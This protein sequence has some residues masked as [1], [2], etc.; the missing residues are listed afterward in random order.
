MARRVGLS[1]KIAAFVLIGAFSLLFV[2]SGSSMSESFERTFSYVLYPVLC[3]QNSFANWWHSWQDGRR[4][5]AELVRLVRALSDE[6]DNLQGHIVE[7]SSRLEYAEDTKELRAFAYRY[8]ELP[9]YGILAQVLVRNLSEQEQFFLVDAG[10]KRGVCKDMIAVYHNGLVGRVID[11]WPSYSKVL[12]IT[13]KLC[14]VACYAA[15]THA[16]GIHE[17][18]NSAAHSKMNQVSHLEEMCL[19][20]LVIS[21]GEG[22]IFPS[23]FGLGVVSS[24]TTENLFYQIEVEPLFDMQEIA[25]CYLFAKGAEVEPCE[26]V[27]DSDAPEEKKDEKGCG[28]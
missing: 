1:K 5:H 24:F 18:M 26:V 6:R 28:V 14:K 8:K 20:D 21:S 2:Q 23:G 25:Y 17:G 22:L 3:V 12:L 19:G 16:H 11:V 27:S 7:L 13:D 9:S 4:N 15:H 10:E